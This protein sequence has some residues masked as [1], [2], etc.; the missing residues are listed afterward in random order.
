MSLASKS[1]Y[2]TPPPQ[3]KVP[4]PLGFC[5]TTDGEARETGGLRKLQPAAQRGALE[6]LNTADA[7]GGGAQVAAPD[8]KNRCET[9]WRRCKNGTTCDISGKE[10]GW[11]MT[12]GQ[13]LLLTS[14]FSLSIDRPQASQA[15]R[16]NGAPEPLGQHRAL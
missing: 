9:T 11:G 12:P 10:K 15:L 14:T 13:L 2:Y 8:L 3:T 4:P 7:Q 5:R 6:R 16:T 1:N